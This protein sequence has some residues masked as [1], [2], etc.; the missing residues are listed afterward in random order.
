MRRRFF[1]EKFEAGRA[2]LLG[3]AAEHLCRVLR[4]EPGQLYELSNGEQI[5]LGRV[6][7]VARSGRPGLSRIEFAL[8]ELV[9]DDRPAREIELLLSIVKFDRFEW[10]LEK[11]TELGATAITPLA[12]ARSENTLIRAAPKR[13]LRWQKILV[14][15]AEQSRRRR[16]PVLAAVAVPETSFPA[17]RAPLKILFSERPDAPPLRQVLRNHSGEDAAVAIGP[18][19]GWTERELAASEQ[20]GFLRAS[21]GG[22]ILRTETA[23]VA[24][25]AILGYALGEEI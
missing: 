16:P 7:R 22:N 21:L 10:C 13:A 25:L 8:V 15:S 2:E 1:V 3:D 14:A 18:E 20:H 5:W 12:A 23:V 9:A 19:G 4:A 24:S 11:A 6:E 17:A